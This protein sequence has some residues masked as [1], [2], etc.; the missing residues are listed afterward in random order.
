MINSA[1]QIA[2]TCIDYL[3][4]GDRGVTEYDKLS[5][6]SR[7]FIEKVEREVGVPVTII[8]TGPDMEETIDLREEKL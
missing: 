5:E 3:V 2:L 4:P 6:K 7:E 1:S 8:S